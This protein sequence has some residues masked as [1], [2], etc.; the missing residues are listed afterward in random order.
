MVFLL[1]KVHMKLYWV[2]KPLFIT[3]PLLLSTILD[4]S[5]WN[6]PEVIFTYLLYIK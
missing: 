4:L 5:V 3:A 6:S 1:Y 2:E